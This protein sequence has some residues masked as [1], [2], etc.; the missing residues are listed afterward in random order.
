MHVNSVASSSKVVLE[1][2][3]NVQA[4]SLMGHKQDS[5]QL[6]VGE[7]RKKGL[8][9]RV[10]YELSLVYMHISSLIPRLSRSV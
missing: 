5:G 3:T 10:T 6:L 7:P 8:F 4:N 2:H 1:Y 9:L